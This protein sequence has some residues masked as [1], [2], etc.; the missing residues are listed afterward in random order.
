MARWKVS[1]PNTVDVGTVVV[2]VEVLVDVEVLVGGVVV[3]VVDDVVVE[4]GEVDCVAF[5][6]RFANSSSNQTRF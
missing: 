1:C 6:N 2:V 4:G 3:V 5:A